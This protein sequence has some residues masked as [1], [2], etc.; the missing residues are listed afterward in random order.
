VEIYLHSPNTPS[1]RGAQ[2]KHRDSFTFTFTFYVQTWPGREDDHS[3]TSVDE[4][5]NGWNYSSTLLYVF[6][7]AWKFVNVYYKAVGISRAI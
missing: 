3:P 1:W 2:L 5:E 4:V 7:A 6:M